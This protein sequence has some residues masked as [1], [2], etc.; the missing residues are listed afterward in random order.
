MGDHEKALNILVK[1]LGDFKAAEDYCLLNGE[2][3]GNNS[4]NMLLHVL[5]ATYLNPNLRWVS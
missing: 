2:G 1:Q 3:K 5:L 4:H